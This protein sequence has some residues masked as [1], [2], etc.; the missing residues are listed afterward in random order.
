MLERCPPGPAR[1][2]LEAE[3]ARLAAALDDV[4]AV[5]LRAQ[6]RWP[7]SGLDIPPGGDG[8]HRPLS[9]AAAVG[10]Q[11]AEAVTMAAIAARSGDASTALDRAAAVT[12]TVDLVVTTVTTAARTA[13]TR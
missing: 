4:L 10:A 11:A 8:C 7:S 6:Q 1:D 9:R 5:C 13:E 2:A 12:R 3:G